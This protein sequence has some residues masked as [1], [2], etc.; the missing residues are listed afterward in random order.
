M[1]RWNNP[2]CGFQNG[3]KAFH[4]GYWKGKKLSKKH[5]QKMSEAHGGS[6]NHMWKGGRSKNQAGYIYI[7]NPNHPFANKD[8]CIF[9]HRLVMEKHLGRYLTPKEVV[10]HINGIKD[11]NRIENLKLFKNESEHIKFHKAITPNFTGK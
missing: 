7:Y 8:N 10:H 2:N 9:E 4:K 5:K 1:P 3:H 6:K 11:D